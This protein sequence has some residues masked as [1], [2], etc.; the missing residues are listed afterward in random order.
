MPKGSR[1]EFLMC[2]LRLLIE[3]SSEF[4]FSSDHGDHPITRDHPIADTNKTL[5]SS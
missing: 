3:E 1:G 5:G 4:G 2:D